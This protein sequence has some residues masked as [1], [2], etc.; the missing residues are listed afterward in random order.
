M[1]GDE[2]FKAGKKINTV[3][4]NLKPPKY[5]NIY[6]Y[7][8][9]FKPYFH[10]LAEE[11]PS[12]SSGTIASEAK[13]TLDLIRFRLTQR[14]GTAKDAFLFFD[15]DKDGRIEESEFLL[16]LEALNIKLT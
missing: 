11:Y 6:N 10:R 1:R 4:I 3:N 15:V 5:E 7:D 12:Y 2:V 8:P 9:S 13:Q 14:F 16:G